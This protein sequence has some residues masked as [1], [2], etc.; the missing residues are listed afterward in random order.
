MPVMEITPK[1]RN[2][3]LDVGED[4]TVAKN[5]RKPSTNVSA[6]T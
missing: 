5:E 3:G 1:P 4:E 6:Q 2:C